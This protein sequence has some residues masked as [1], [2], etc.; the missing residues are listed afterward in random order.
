VGRGPVAEATDALLEAYFGQD[1]LTR[2]R[3]L[4]EI[5]DQREMLEAQ[6]VTQ[7]RQQGA[8]WDQ[9]GLALGVSKQAALQ[10]FEWLKEL[11]I[12]RS[13]PS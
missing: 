9:I 6:A 12:E 11:G 5:K 10:K 2:L 7:A 1:G 4:R 3:A 13:R 8:T